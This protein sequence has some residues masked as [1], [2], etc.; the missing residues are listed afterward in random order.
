MNIYSRLPVCLQEL[1]DDIIY[2][3]GPRYEYIYVL[4]EMSEYFRRGKNLPGKHDIFGGFRGQ[5]NVG[6]SMYWTQLVSKLGYAEPKFSAGLMVSAFHPM[7]KS[8]I[9][10]MVNWLVDRSNA[11]LSDSIRYVS[12]ET[13]M[14]LSI[15]STTRVVRAVSNYVAV[16]METS[17]EYDPNSGRFFHFL[18][19]SYIN[20]LPLMDTRNFGVTNSAWDL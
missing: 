1:V 9:R 6:Q 16:V 8:A 15:P 10:L 7:K 18:G 19:R 2:R 5:Y 14:N 3:T 4:K 12:M 17:D 13:R 11:R 20:D